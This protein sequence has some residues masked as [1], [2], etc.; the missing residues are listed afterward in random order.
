[1]HKELS[2]AMILLL[3]LRGQVSKGATK[4]IINIGE[5]YADY[6]GDNDDD[7]GD[8]NENDNDDDDDDH[9]NIDYDDDNEDDNEEDDEAGW[10]AAQQRAPPE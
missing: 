10:P 3:R 2:R 8:D 4:M 5:V 7:D 1:M 9:H 6:D